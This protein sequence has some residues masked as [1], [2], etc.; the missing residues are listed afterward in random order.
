M[1]ADVLPAL[2]YL[3]KKNIL[4]RDIKS[5]NIFRQG[6]KFQI[7]DLNVSKFMKIGLAYTQTGTPY[8]ASPEVWRN[9][10]YDAKSD[11]WSFGVVVYE[12]CTLSPPFKAKSM[13][14]LYRKVVAGQYAP[15]STHYSPRLREF[16]KEC[17][18]VKKGQR[19]KAEQLASSYL[20]VPATDPTPEDD[21]IGTI[22][23]P[24]NISHL[25]ERLPKSRYRQSEDPPQSQASQASQEGLNLPRLR[26]NYSISIQKIAP[27]GKKD[28][29]LAVLPRQVASIP[30]EN[31]L[32][33]YKKKNK[34]LPVIES[35]VE[36]VRIR[37]Y[38][39]KRPEWWG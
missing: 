9:E 8:Y 12:L 32:L 6:S 38:S 31:D 22:R 33:P 11:V 16:I 15:V 23:M 29:S 20:A 2:A 34:L 13:D 39:Y 17:L 5:A 27:I 19:P 14:D 4:H 10:S 1:V 25:K 26:S 21:L 24:K 7:A 35:K 37:Q 3:H 36:A 28:E 30:N 18:T